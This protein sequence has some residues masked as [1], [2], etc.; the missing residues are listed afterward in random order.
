M[1]AVVFDDV[2]KKHEFFSTEIE[3][4]FVYITASSS[5]VRSTIPKSN[6]GHDRTNLFVLFHIGVSQVI[7]HV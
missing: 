1:S 4:Y 5:I 3:C 6:I 7:L 2:E